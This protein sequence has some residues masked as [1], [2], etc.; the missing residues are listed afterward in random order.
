MSLELWP[1]S[2]DK[3][4]F[5]GH[6]V[7]E[8]LDEPAKLMIGDQEAMKQLSAS[9][10]ICI[11]GLTISAFAQD[12]SQLQKIGNVVSV[13]KTDKT[14]VM[15]CSDQSQ[16]QLSILAPDLVRVRVS[17]AQALPEKDHS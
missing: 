17:F 3:L 15:N 11:L 16:V 9:G 13:T 12:V 10:M 14:L 7:G 4:K 2:N 1:M 8:M 6:W 5:V